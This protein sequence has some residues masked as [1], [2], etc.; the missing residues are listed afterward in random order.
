MNVLTA[1]GQKFKEKQ[2]IFLNTAVTIY[3]LNSQREKCK[4]LTLR[5]TKEILLIKHGRK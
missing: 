1:L 4:M 2:V 5:K 3:E